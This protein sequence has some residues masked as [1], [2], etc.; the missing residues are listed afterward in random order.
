[1]DAFTTTWNQLMSVAVFSGIA[2]SILILVA[3]LLPKSRFG[4]SVNTFIHRN[5][6]SAG[7]FISFAALVSSLVYSNVI[8]YEP[9][10]LC[11]YA[12]VAFY[13]QV[14]MF[15]MAV[16]KKER[17]IVD[18]ALGLTVFGLIITAYHSYVQWAGA[19]LLPCSA[20]GTS[21]V[22]RVVF[23]YG[24]ITIPFMGF[25]GFLVMFLCLV[26]SKKALPVKG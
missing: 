25:V 12:R 6:L 13:P 14:I 16:F 4:M 5:I 23:E 10:L 8:G 9:C 20:S 1:M 18:Y 21:C 15:A 11:W 3:I 19:T 2:T 26:S 24:F 22:T 7:F 17:S